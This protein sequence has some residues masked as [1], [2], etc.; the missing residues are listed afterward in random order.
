[1][2]VRHLD[3]FEPG[4]ELEERQER[5]YG[6]AIYLKR[7]Y[8]NQTWDEVLTVTELRSYNEESGNIE[9]FAI[10]GKVRLSHRH[11]CG[12]QR[13][14]NIKEIKRMSTDKKA[15]KAKA[16][17]AVKAPKE[18]AT[19]APAEPK[20]NRHE[21]REK[22]LALREGGKKYS[23]I[24]AEVGFANAGAACNAVRSAQEA[25]GTYVPKVKKA[26]E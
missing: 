10:A 6:R 9:L 8:S 11:E 17:K 14:I 5:I 3:P 25:N 7:E 24:A 18:K 21:K 4:L 20:G 19:K 22:A 13:T 1:M 26:A 15:T 16:A 12:Q 23:E 2:S